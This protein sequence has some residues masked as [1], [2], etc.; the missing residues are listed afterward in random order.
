MFGADRNLVKQ[1]MGQELPS[2]TVQGFDIPYDAGSQPLAS[3]SDIMHT[4]QGLISI[5]GHC[6]S[7]CQMLK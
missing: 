7:D 6:K 3:I 1:L 5:I 4:C 2:Y